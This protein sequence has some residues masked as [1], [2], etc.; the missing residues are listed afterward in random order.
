MLTS[1]SLWWG[2]SGANEVS[3]KMCNP[4]G[5]KPCFWTSKSRKEHVHC[6][7]DHLCCHCCYQIGGHD[8][9]GQNDPPKQ[10]A[11]P[12][13]SRFTGVLPKSNNHEPKRLS[14]KEWLVWLE[15]QCCFPTQHPKEDSNEK[16]KNEIP[17]GPIRFLWETGCCHAAH[18]SHYKWLFRRKHLEGHPASKYL[19]IPICKPFRLFGRGTTP[20]RGLTTHSCFILTKWGCPPSAGCLP[21]VMLYGWALIAIQCRL[22]HRCQ[23][24]IWNNRT[25]NVDVIMGTLPALQNLHPPEIAVFNQGVMSNHCPIIFYEILTSG[26]WASWNSGFHPP[27][28]HDIP[29]TKPTIK[30]KQGNKQFKHMV[31]H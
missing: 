7:H 18:M 26:N 22:T 28:K 14:S 29:P 17:V 6:S 11:W 20:V 30:V 27:V 19:V 3:K 25:S 2:F 15:S 10:Q 4:W 23:L 31:S 5:K 21:S 1:K 8:Q 13:R 12:R 24:M 16:V 9:C